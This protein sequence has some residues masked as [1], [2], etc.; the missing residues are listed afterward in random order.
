M[1]LDTKNICENIY[2]NTKERKKQCP[3]TVDK[4]SIAQFV[5]KY[6]KG[7]NLL[8]SFSLCYKNIIFEDAVL[9]H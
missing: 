5:D 4:K 1:V 3:L 6:E 9:Q 2:E 8:L 7:H